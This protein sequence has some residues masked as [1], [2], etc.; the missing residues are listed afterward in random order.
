MKPEKEQTSGLVCCSV[1]EVF[2]STVECASDNLSNL[3]KKPGPLGKFIS[4]FIK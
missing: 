2:I 3:S 1:L 4:L